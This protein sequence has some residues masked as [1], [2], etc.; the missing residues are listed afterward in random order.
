MELGDCKKKLGIFSKNPF[1]NL[2]LT[3][4]LVLQGCGDADGVRGHGP[5]EEMALLY[6]QRS[7]KRL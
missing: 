7:C 4:V 1:Q 2:H 5:W 3:S 6:T